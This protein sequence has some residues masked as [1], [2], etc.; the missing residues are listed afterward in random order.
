MALIQKNLD[1]F[2]SISKVQTTCSLYPALSYSYSNYLELFLITV[3]PLLHTTNLYNSD[4][5]LFKI[6]PI[7]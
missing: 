5:W 4:I 3:D 7:H 2:D 6:V 1:G